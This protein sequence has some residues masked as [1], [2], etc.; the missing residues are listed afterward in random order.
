MEELRLAAVI[1]V[2]YQ[3]QERK[4]V[5]DFPVA[6]KIELLRETA[7]NIKV[8]FLVAWPLRPYPHA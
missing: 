8:L 2:R 5:R 1:R 6:E 3:G 7:K 4:L